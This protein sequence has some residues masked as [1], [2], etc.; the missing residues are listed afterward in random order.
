M[1]MATTRGIKEIQVDFLHR[2]EV[3]EED[4]SS[5]HSASTVRNQT[6]NALEI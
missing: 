5:V 1:A 6:E 4:D 2:S 3:D